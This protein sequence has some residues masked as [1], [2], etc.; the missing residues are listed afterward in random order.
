MGGVAGGFLSR[1]AFPAPLPVAARG[2]EMNDVQRQPVSPS[3]RSVR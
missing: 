1:I 3:V 2:A